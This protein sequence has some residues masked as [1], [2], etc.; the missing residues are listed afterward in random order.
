[1]RVLPGELATDIMRSMVF[2]NVANKVLPSP[3]IASKNSDEATATKSAI[4]TSFR[5]NTIA[6][7][8]S[9]GNIEYQDIN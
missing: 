8:M 5:Q 3:C 4:I 2:K 6:I 9:G 7:A 1:M